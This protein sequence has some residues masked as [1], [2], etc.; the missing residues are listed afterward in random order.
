MTVQF[1]T[2]SDQEEGREE[3]ERE[4]EDVHQQRVR[5]YN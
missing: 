1:Q 5:P 4:G 3:E 2:R